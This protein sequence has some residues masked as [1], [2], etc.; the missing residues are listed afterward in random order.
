MTD[1][2]AFSGERLKMA[3]TA[4]NATRDDQ[5][6]RVQRRR[7]I[8]AG[9]LMVVGV[10]ISIAS[11]YLIRQSEHHRIECDFEAGDRARV[12][13]IER[14]I[15]HKIL[16]LESFV[17]FYSGSKAVD[18]SEFSTFAA[19]FLPKHDDTETI[20]WVPRVSGADRA[21]FEALA[22]GEG[23]ADFQITETDP[24]GQIV[25]ALARDEYFPAWF[26]EGNGDNKSVLGLDI[27]RSATHRM[28]FDA[29]RDTGRLQAT[30]PFVSEHYGRRQLAISIVA[31]IYHNGMPT[32]SIA[33]RRDSLV[34][35]V[36]TTV[37]I[38]NLLEH[39]TE[40]WS[41]DEIDVHIY[42]GRTILADGSQHAV[43]ADGAGAYR[44]PEWHEL[45]DIRKG[46]HCMT[47]TDVAG[48]E[49]SIF[50]TATEQFHAA[51]R[52]WLSWLT[53]VGGLL[54]SFVLA[55]HLVSVTR[56]AGRNGRLA[57]QLSLTNQGLNTEITQRI[58]AEQQQAVAHN[59]LQE[60]INALPDVIHV[61][62]LEYRII[63]AN[64]AACEAAGRETLA[65]SGL[66]CH[67]VSHHRKIL[68]NA[69]ADPCPIGEIVKS[70]APVTVEHVH[71]DSEGNEVFV[72][73]C[74][75]P[76]LDA[77]GQVI[78]IIEICRDVSERTRADAERADLAK[79]PSEDPHPVL[80]IAADGMVLYA[81]A[82]AVPLLATE[83]FESLQLAPP[84]WRETV[85]TALASGCE[86]L[87]EIESQ[88]RIFGFHVIPI[89]EANYTNW[90]GLDITEQRRV[91]EA[92][93]RENA[94]LSAM[95]SSMEEGVV[96]ADT[97][98]TIVEVNDYFCRL[99][100]RRREELIG[101]ALTSCHDCEVMGRILSRIDQFR[102]R[103]DTEPLVVQRPLG[104]KDMIFRMQPIYRDGRYD[105]VLLNII[106]VSTLAQARRDAETANAAKSEFLAN[107]SHEIRTP[108]TAILGFTEQ[109]KDPALTPIDRDNHL[110]VIERNGHNLL[111]LINDILDLSKIDSGNFTIEKSQ[112]SAASVVADVASMMHVRA[113]SKGVLLSVEYTGQFPATILTDPVRLRQILVNLVGN[114]IKFTERGEVRIVVTFLP[115]Q[116]GCKPSVRFD[117]IDTGIGVPPKKLDVL[118]NPFIQADASTSRKYG[119]T[120]LGLAI[121]RHIVEL[122]DGELSVQ[123]RLGYGSTFSV[124][125]PAGNLTDVPM[126]QNPSEC[127]QD[128][129]P[130]TNQHA[131]DQQG[132]DT[133]PLDGLRIL[134]AEDGRDNQL[135]IST[136]L[137]KAG[138]NVE[139]A[140]NGRVAVEMA[141]GA[142]ESEFDVILMDMQM[143][144][145]DGYQATAACRR[146][147]LSCPIIALTAHAMAGDREKCISTGCT[148]YCTKPIDRL[149]LI[150]MIANLAHPGEI[151]SIRSEFADDLDIAGI[152]NEFVAKL[153]AM[154]S[155][156]RQALAHCH[157]AELQRLAHQLKGAGGN[158]GY[159]VLTDAA[160]VVE[161]TAKAED[162]EAATLSIR[163]L[164]SL[165]EAVRVGHTSE[166]TTEGAVL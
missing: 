131:T 51:R 129:S 23:F 14:E 43:L 35:F 71:Q 5:Q 108:M 20:T 40:R 142:N 125:V 38:Q 81:N 97:D 141:S 154:V 47:T 115:A 130:V 162:T 143:P 21:D 150:S 41:S 63:L 72:E 79:F 57:E 54:M 160:R 86:Q 16:V 8:I 119:G 49:W 144:E 18:R 139:I 100:N 87:H 46:L 98:N 127:L 148:D 76:I 26:V 64:R 29:S 109:L 146:N 120:G 94:K 30:D 42:Q 62:D 116:Q 118:F 135:L 56:Y 96:F 55:G 165:C 158:Y 90:Y 136:V 114:A 10:A 80:R 66:T 124:T 101:Q 155:E 22:R 11:W 50:C 27:A 6:D 52:T 149:Q 117:V 99:A 161:E 4:M 159:P 53:L 37:G 126:L 112:C 24:T 19:P 77:S 111:R 65:G 107:M 151:D 134:L 123:S 128:S 95:I 69:P 88:G 60:V 1:Q 61:I 33:D 75:A 2:K 156:M 133:E 74:G 58:Q 140:E 85:E 91:E 59:F 147:G 92:A 105:G 83:Q 70:K 48:Q 73:V 78:Q 104:D 44:V 163:R 153:P 25:R 12:V 36:V 113:D 67:E 145:M 122:L 13:A 45:E 15:E 9:V 7:Y 93:G 34:G 3:E 84:Q 110:A 132:T 89:Q 152:L 103:A 164:A 68:C 39:A 32:D 157:H 102:S 31:P 166:A 138:A 28:G 121:T 106:D 82:A 17:A 137:R